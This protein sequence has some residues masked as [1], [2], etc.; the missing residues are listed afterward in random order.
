MSAAGK[1]LAVFRI[2]RQEKDKRFL[3]DFRVCEKTKAFYLLARGA[4]TDRLFCVGFDGKERWA[5]KGGVSTVY[6][7]VGLGGAFD[8]DD[9]GTL[10]VLA[11]RSDVVHRAS[12]DGKPLGKI[13]LQMGKARPAPNEHW[14]SSLR[15]HGNHLLLQRPG[16]T[17][18]FQ[19]YD[20]RSGALQLV[21]HTDHERVRVTFDSD[22]WT[23][24]TNVPFRIRLR[25]DGR[26]L[27]PRW[28][29][30]ARPFASVDYREFP[31]VDDV[32][33]VPADCAGLYVV[34]VTPELLPGQALAASG[35]VVRTVVEV[36]HPKTKGTA[37]VLTAENRMDFG[38]GEPI[39]FAVEVRGEGNGE[40]AVVAALTAG[41]AVLARCEAKVKWGARA[42]FTIP[43][44]LTAA[45]RPGRY[46]LT[47]TARG[48]TCVSQQ[49]VIGPGKKATPFH[50]LLYGDM[51]QY[52]PSADVWD[53]PDLVAAHAAR[54]RR[55]GV[56]LVVDRLGH[57]LNLGDLE[58]DVNN[59]GE[60]SSLAK[61][62]EGRR[63]GVAPKKV[64]MP[65]PLLQTQAAYSTAGIEQMAILRG[66]D[67]GL[68][69]G[70]GFDARKPQ[71]YERDITRVTK[72]LLPY[73]S[74]RGWI[75][76]SN[77]WLWEH[78]G[79]KAA[80]TPDER[81]RYEVALKRANDTGAWSPVLDKVSGYRLGYSVEA[82]ALFRASLAKIAPGKVT[83]ISGPYRSPDCY[84]PITFAKVDEVDLHYQAEQIQPPDTV[85]HNVDFQKRP[86]RRG[87]GHPELHNDAGTGEQALPTL[88]QML[89]RGADGVGC[90]GKVPYWGPQR[91]DPRSSYY[92]SVSIYRALGG[93]L[94]QYGPWLTTLQNNDRVAIVVSGRMCRIDDWQGI[95]GRYFTR[96]FEAYQSCL[97]AH[98]PASFVFTEDLTP[99]ALARYKVV[100]VVGQTVTMEPELAQALARAKADG[101]AIFHDDTCRKE[102]VKDF[103]S[104]GVR[105]DKVEN[106]PSVWQDDTAYVRFPAYYRK[107]LPALKKALGRVLRPVGEVESADVLLSERAAE[108]GRYLFVVNNTVPDLSPGQMWRATLFIAS[109]VPREVPV[110]L[111]G[112]APAVYDVFAGKQVRP[113]KGVLRADCRA[114]PARLFAVLP[115]AIAK[116]ELRG[117]KSVKAGQRFA[118]AV[119]VQD[120]AGRPIKASIPVR[121]RLLDG[122]KV[123]EERFLAAGS[124]GASGTMT[125]V[126]NPAKSAQVLE[127]TELFSGRA[128]E[129]KLAVTA[130]EAPVRLVGEEKSATAAADARV[131]SA[132]T[133]PAF[134]AAEKAFGPHIRDVIVSGDGSLAVM[135]AMNWDHNLYAVDVK[136]GELRWR[137][138]AGHY[139]AFSPRA[140][141][142][143]VAVQGIDLRSAE[144]YHL[145]LADRDGKFERRFALY[146]LPRRLP[147]RF[148]PG[149]FLKDRINQFAVPASGK[150]V[151]SAGDLG[152]A[153]WSR[154]GKLLWSQ[155]WWKTERRTATLAALDNETLLLAER[156]KLTAYAATTGKQRWQVVLA[157]SGEARQ[158]EV[159]RDGKTCAVAATTEGGRV[160]V[161]RE[162]KLVRTI[163]GGLAPPGT[164]PIGFARVTA[165]VATECNA[166]AVS[167]DGSL[168]AV[169]S[170]N[171]LRLYSLKD[172]LQWALPGDDVLHFPR[173]AADGKRIAVSSELG[174]V[175]VVGRDGKLLLE[176]DQGAIAV[177]AW[178]PDGDLLLANWMGTVCRLD[179]KYAERW[180]THLQPAATDMRGK[181]LA[182]DG[183]PTTRIA[184]RGNAEPKPAPLTPNLL[185][186]KSAFI[187]YVWVNMN[188]HVEN[189]VMFAHDSA[190]LMD[191][192]ADAPAAPWISWQQMHWYAEGDPFSYL[193]IDT[194]RTQLRV[195]GITLV[196]DAAH[197]ESWLRDAALEYWDAAR[198][199]WVHVQPLLSNAA[200]H[201]HKF[202]RP[203][204]AARFRI[205]LPKMLCGN[206]RL[207]EIVF[208]GTKLGPSH[209]DV[210]AKRPV[211][212]LFDEGDD[213]KGYLLRGTM[214]FK[215]AYS[216]GRC[217][218]VE[219]GQDAVAFAP[220]LEGA[221]VFGHTL[222][223]WDFE[224]V[225]RPKAGQ[226]RYLQ[227]AWR[228]LTPGTKGIALRVDDGGAGAVTLLA[229][230]RPPGEVV[231]NPRK[232]ADRPP[233]EWAVVRV[234]LWQVFKRP[235]RIRGLRLASTGG[236]AAFDQLL[237]GRTEKDLA[238]V[239][240]ISNPSDAARRTDF[241]SV[242]RP[243]DAAAVKIVYPPARAARLVY[244]RPRR[245]DR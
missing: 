29:V 209:P 170:A 94:K 96:L 112:P 120:E 200:V 214:T 99:R 81:A 21:R 24:G 147:H 19:R 68:P 92:G 168:I 90:S 173:F 89:M 140:I 63:S 213:L 240:R 8:V 134:V 220:W 35:H 36:R 167:P 180:R 58:W 141:A 61:L 186:P 33:Q 211:A 17:E 221:K 16:A 54:L 150:W 245:G 102:L 182:N 236:P 139:F 226:Y 118:W 181:L 98:Y 153:V 143:G 50:F 97:R 218:T 66:E 95:G 105:F 232:L 5:Y 78:R 159:S 64:A 191:G 244:V 204:E 185:D 132:R 207:G 41:K 91:D 82:Q 18:F 188:G 146:G 133:S 10:Y 184:F 45:L 208:H 30:W 12:P 43:G 20:L 234:D 56:N 199:R 197:P 179:G 233:G 59:K 198:E 110:G 128:T 235:V 161:L 129:V 192:K 119:A 31:L 162:G 136:T 157:Q 101:V 22:V 13:T 75:W 42:T 39:P 131:T 87:W 145:Y 48:L 224:I 38:R 117:P 187:K 149:T 154:D 86:G 85:S 4:P 34:K 67:A 183:A 71:E 25:A 127:A 27:T 142:N 228:A 202:A 210:I 100:L 74:F 231:L 225:E 176:R 201:T 229:G 169:T 80:K 238:G 37:T 9:E 193:L 130:P 123:I 106:D 52:Y 114:L 88:F 178:L 103:P 84:P 242:L 51:T 65:S 189:G 203:V 46:A 177:P 219:A 6:D 72:A 138:R 116:V 222:P 28:R 241:Q 237:L 23:A 115:A 1:T 217:L 175:Y 152:L 148:V 165:A 171:Q 163:A 44:T 195:T 53:A 227:F 151:A 194:Y 57:G 196:E 243:I 76:S 83:A 11:G 216:G 160:F 47:V 70:N 212:V 124:K 122:A 69:L 32:L 205:V 107:N 60:L 111:A 108:A 158:V 73:P 77:S 155:D 109:R 93:L 223:N 113:E 55:L 166:V 230:D 49:V 121:L 137:Q 206:L 135:N 174:T 7:S 126:L 172:G 104:L 156:L 3:W 164:S 15:A 62:L 239:G 190:A 144:G 14:F 40:V 79:S 26:E 215:G 2:E 125:A